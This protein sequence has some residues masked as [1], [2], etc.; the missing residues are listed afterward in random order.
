MSLPTQNAFFHEPHCPSFVF[1]FSLSSRSLPGLTEETF[2]QICSCFQSAGMSLCW[3]SA[4]F[5]RPCPCMGHPA[6]FPQLKCSLWWSLGTCSQPSVDKACGVHFRPYES[7]IFINNLLSRSCLLLSRHQ[8]LLLCYI[9]LMGST[10]LYDPAGSEPY[11]GL[12]LVSYVGFIQCGA[13]RT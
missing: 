1:P 2:L 8:W 7:K 4:S 13:G 3:L 9:I 11:T 5:C 10:L 12:Y 6:G